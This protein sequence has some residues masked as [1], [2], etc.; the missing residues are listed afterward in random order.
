MSTK[1]TP[2]NR[3]INA[4]APSK[5]GARVP[6]QDRAATTKARPRAH[7]KRA[8]SPLEVQLRRALAEMGLARARRVLAPFEASFDD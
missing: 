5:T 4:P 1:K 2:K 7:A 6:K 8:L 3:P